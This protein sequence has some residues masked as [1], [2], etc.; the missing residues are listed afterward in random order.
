MVLFLWKQW[1]P[2]G[3]CWPVR[4]VV[5]LRASSIGS[6]ASLAM[7]AQRCELFN[8]A[9]SCSINRSLSSQAFASVMEELFQNPEVATRM[10]LVGQQHVKK[11]F[12]RKTFGRQL[13]FYLNELCDGTRE[14]EHSWSALNAMLI[15]T[16][17]Y[18][19]VLIFL[20]LRF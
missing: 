2:A 11:K 9:E 12:S 15:G 4:M 17:F 16:I 6:P 10:G 5:Q 1:R 7:H 8:R 20:R 18:I 13:H 19:A 14:N 3:Q